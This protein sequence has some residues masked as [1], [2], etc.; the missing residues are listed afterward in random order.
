[1]PTGPKKDQLIRLSSTLCT[2]LDESESREWLLAD[3][4]GGYAFGTVAGTPTRRYHGLLLAATDPPAGRTLLVHSIHERLLIGEEVVDLGT[5]RWADGSVNPRGYEILSCFQL[6]GRTPTWTWSVG[7]ILFQ[8]RIALSDGVVEIRW[9]LDGT[10]HP[11]HLE[12]TLL[13]SNRSHHAL[14]QA[15]DE[16]PTTTVKEGG[17]EIDWPGETPRT[18]HVV[19]DGELM[20]RGAWWRG[21]KLVEESARGYP[22]VED[23][24]EALVGT[25]VVPESGDVRLR[26]GLDAEAVAE[27]ENLVT[28]AR[29]TDE[30]CARAA[31]APSMESFHGRLAIAAGQFLV[32]RPLPDGS[33]SMTIIAG[34]PWFADWGRDAMFS[35]PGLTLATGRH[36]DAASILETFAAHEKNGLIPNL[37]TDDGSPPL[38][39]TVD[40]SLF[41]IEAVLRWF[42]ET[43]D[44]TRLRGLWPT[45]ESIITNYKKGTLH[46]ICVDESDGLLHAGESGLQLTW[47]DARV[48]THV[49]T[50]RSGKPVEINALWHAALNT[51]ATIAKVLGE[52]STPFEHDAERVKKSFDKFWNQGIGCLFD[53]ID[54]QG[55][56]DGAIRPNQLF[57][58]ALDPPLLEGDRARSVLDVVERELMIPMG[59]RTLDSGSASFAPHYEGNPGQRDGAYHQGTAWPWLLGVWVRAQHA[60]HGSGAHEII[61]DLFAQA[62]AHLHVAGLGSISEILDAVSPYTP[63]GCPAQAW[64]V[65]VFLDMI[66]RRK[67]SSTPTEVASRE[68]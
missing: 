61:D 15:S 37:F 41:F 51:A 27:R 47:M 63:R 33:E 19:A 36:A 48:G 2:R 7:D 8:R 13:V 9:N 1:M 4:L 18:L 17:A 25:L 58:L 35:L 30:A 32:N 65:A 64:S 6:E 12:Y 56:N 57:A 14:L 22:D 42:E 54:G 20:A 43:G 67:L 21:F 34:Y 23:A 45:I 59:V 40:A 38:Y 39:N 53:V 11:V 28:S 26:A 29:E 49:I 10:N 68:R 62:E 3:G 55:G 44:E 50:P 66:E 16:T 31:G 24:W 46:G 60:V 52:D 5:A